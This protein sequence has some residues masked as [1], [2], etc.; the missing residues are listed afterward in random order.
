M[1]NRVSGSQLAAARRM[2][3][4]SRR[5]LAEQ[6]DTCWQTILSYEIRGDTPL[7]ETA[8]LNRLVDALEG[9]GAEFRG[10]GGVL[11]VRAM[12]INRA[13]VHDEAAA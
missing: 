10:D 5:R 9:R 11:F 12:P 6:A 2:V 13:A 8:I 4:L 1:M 7:P 3:G